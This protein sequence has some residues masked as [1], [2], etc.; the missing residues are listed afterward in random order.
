MRSRTACAPPASVPP[1]GI[2]GYRPAT[3]PASVSRKK[4]LTMNTGIAVII[5]DTAVLNTA[6]H[7]IT[8][9]IGGS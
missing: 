5:L 6:S 1:K 7:W 4:F 2:C 9:C 8:G 3:N